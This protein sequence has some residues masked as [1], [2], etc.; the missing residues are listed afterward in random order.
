MDMRRGGCIDFFGDEM[1]RWLLIP[2]SAA[3][4]GLLLWQGSVTAQ[5]V[6]EGLI[7]CGRSVIPALFPFMV[8]VRFLVGCG[9]GGW[10][11]PAVAVLVVGAVGGYPLGASTVGQLYGCAQLSREQASRLLCCCNN[12]GPAFILTFLGEG[13]FGSLRTGLFLWGVHLTSAAAMAMLFFPTT[14]NSLPRNTQQKPPATA[15]VEAV[16]GA[17]D[18]MARVCGFVVLFSVVTALLQHFGIRWPALLGALELTCGA[19]SLPR[20]AGG[21][22]LGSAL[23]GWGGVSVHC[24]TAAVL[25]ETDLPVGRY[26]LAK[27]LQGGIS[28]ILAAGVVRFW[29]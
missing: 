25:S 16:T 23:L 10:F 15:F 5:A 21:V 22:I 26:V 9:M 13:I 20:N 18:T 2:G 28:A 8:A 27:A 29:A 11:S 17:V 14:G 6:R 24:Q 4:L 7:L 19:G 1:K 12:A 3:V